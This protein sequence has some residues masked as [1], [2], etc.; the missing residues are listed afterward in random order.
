[1]IF[2]PSYL[3][4]DLGQKTLGISISEAGVFSVN[5]KTLNF[6]NH[7]YNYLLKPLK[8]LIIQKNIKTII[9]GFPK[10]M[11]NDLGI[12]GLISI[13][14]KKKLEDYLKFDI[15]IILWDE[16]LTTKQSLIFLKNNNKNKKK[17]KQLKDEIAAMFILQNFLDYK[18]NI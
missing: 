1:M 8:I 2:F 5:L 15:K 16:R 11:N 13:D 10:H 12:K 6:P 14:F 7:Q 17:I 18:N 9:L 3:G 4:L